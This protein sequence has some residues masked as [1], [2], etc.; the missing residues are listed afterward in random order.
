M[1]I[2]NVQII[3]FCSALIVIIMFGSMVASMYRQMNQHLNILLCRVKSLNYITW[4]CWWWILAINLLP[5]L[6]GLYV[7]MFAL[8]VCWN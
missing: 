3:I 4:S 7:S 6:N 8:V 5:K 1:Q 2:S